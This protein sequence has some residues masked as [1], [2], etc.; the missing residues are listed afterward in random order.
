MRNLIILFFLV[1]NTSYSQ[2]FFHI[3]KDESYDY[4]KDGNK[5]RNLLNCID[6]EALLFKLNNQNFIIQ[7]KDGFYKVYVDED[8]KRVISS[9]KLA[10][11]EAIE[12][13]TILDSLKSINPKYLDITIDKNGKVMIVNDG[14][15][16]EVNFFKKEYR[17]TLKSNNPELYIEEKFPHFEER[18]KFLKSI[19]KLN[20]IFFDST[21]N[22][23][24][25]LDTI[26]LKLKNSKNLNKLELN[27]ERNHYSLLFSGTK[28]ITLTNLDS[29]HDLMI[30]RKSLQ[31]DKSKII[32]ID[33]I[34]K[35]R[36]NFVLNLFK[37]KV[38]YII[39]KKHLIRVHVDNLN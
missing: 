4:A 13:S 17:L 15:E 1:F 29:D 16:Y 37:N 10:S 2:D 26:Y 39:E 21:Y 3:S 7:K 38:I 32:N 19:K 5:Y 9:A 31:K 8:E 11:K 35:Y 30:K 24:N 18:I 25:K 20:E 36:Y 28:K 12:C 33:F 22:N 14:I 6:S 34:N 23:V 27:K